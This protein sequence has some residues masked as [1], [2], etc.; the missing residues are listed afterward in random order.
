MMQRGLV[1]GCAKMDSRRVKAL[2]GAVGVS[3]GDLGR[4]MRISF[5]GVDMAV[6]RRWRL[7]KQENEVFAESVLVWMCAHVSP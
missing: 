3:M 2:F 5:P 6:R 7:L 1:V 4:V